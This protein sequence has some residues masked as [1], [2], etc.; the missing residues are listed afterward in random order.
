MRIFWTFIKIFFLI[1]VVVYAVKIAS[2]DK[3][4]FDYKGLDRKVDGSGNSSA[5]KTDGKGSNS[6]RNNDS[7]DNNGNITGNGAN[8]GSPDRGLIRG[9]KYQGTGLKQ[10]GKYPGTE[11]IDGNEQK[12]SGS[13]HNVPGSAANGNTRVADKKTFILRKVKELLLGAAGKDG[14]IV[15]SKE[16]NYINSI[17][18]T[19]K[20]KGIAILSKLNKKSI[21][22]V[23]ELG[24][25]GIQE[26]ELAELEKILSAKLSGQDI[27]DL[28]DIFLNCKAKAQ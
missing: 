19:D 3:L 16:L 22:R 11:L 20:L 26:G 18:V 10:E 4:I 6:A 21:D 9:E 12:A 23:M 2:I 25:D 15:T 17:S 1:A 7:S 27:L 14:S 5:G 24:R 28:Y 8:Y 13:G